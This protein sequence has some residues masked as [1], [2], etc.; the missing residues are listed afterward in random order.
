MNI[1][2]DPVGKRIRIGRRRNAARWPGEAGEV[3]IGTDREARQAHASTQHQAVLRALQTQLCIYHGADAGRI[4][5]AYVF[6][7][8]RKVAVDSLLIRDVAGDADL[9]SAGG[10]YKTFNLQ[11]VLI[12]IEF[13]VQ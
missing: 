9:T 10:A 2:P 5:D 6:S 11:P 3:E 1:E 4:P 8:C 13:A 12:E 7:C